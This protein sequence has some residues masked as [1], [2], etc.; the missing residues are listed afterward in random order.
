MNHSNQPSLACTAFHSVIFNIHLLQSQ[1]QP[2]GR[3]LDSTHSAIVYES[4]PNLPHHR[5]PWNADPE[6]DPTQG[7]GRRAPAF[8]L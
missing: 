8:G 1:R 7:Y 3:P 6:P 4:G 2:H 5:L